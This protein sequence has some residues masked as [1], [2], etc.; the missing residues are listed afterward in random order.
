MLRLLRM[1]MMICW[2][3]E[4]VRRLRSSRA[5]F[6]LSTHG[7]RCVFLCGYQY[8]LARSEMGDGDDG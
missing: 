1:E 4:V 3:E 5:H 8:T 7:M 2:E 6:L